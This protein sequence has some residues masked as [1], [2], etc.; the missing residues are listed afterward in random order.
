MATLEKIRSK[1]VL[2]VSIIFVALFLFIITIIDNPFGLFQDTTSA[3][4]VDGEKISIEEVSKRAQSMQSQAQ[5]QRQMQNE[6]RRMQGLPELPAQDDQDYEFLALND[7]IDETLLKKECERMGIVVTDKEVSDIIVG[8]NANP[9]IV[10]EFRQAFNATPEFILSAINNPAENGL[11]QEDAEQLTQAYKEFETSIEFRLLTWKFGTLMN[12]GINANKLDAQAIHNEARTTYSIA[13]V[14]QLIG[15]GEP[16]TDREVEQFYTDHREEFKLPAPTRHVRYVALNIEPSKL[17]CTKALEKVKGDLEKVRESEAGFDDI[18]LNGAY[19]VDHKVSNLAQV[20]RLNV[21]GLQTFVTGAAPDSVAIL[22][23]RT[24]IASSNPHVTLAK[25]VSRENKVNS[26][27]VN[28]VYLDG[29]LSADSVLTSLNEGVN[30]EGLKGVAFVRPDELQFDQVV[31]WLLD[32]LQTLGAGKYMLVGSGDGQQQIAVAI[33]SYGEPEDVFEFYT[34]RYDIAPSRET[35]EELNTRMQEFLISAPNASSFTQENASA[36]N[37]NVQNSMVS[38]ATP[39]L[40]DDMADFRDLVPWAMNAEI[41]SVSK[42]R[43]NSRGDRMAAVAVVEEYK[44]YVPVT[45]PDM[46]DNL[47]MGAQFEKDANTIINKVAGKGKT[48]SDYATLMN[49]QR[50]D[51]ISS[52]NLSDRRF[53]ELGS[54]R[55]HKAGDLVGPMRWNGNVIVASVIETSDSELPINESEASN[56]FINEAYR[57]IFR[58][59]RRNVLLGNEKVDY[60][61]LRFRGTGEE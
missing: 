23:E 4:K 21:P 27:K 26:A 46:Q 30:P 2:L 36:Q 3:A 56:A 6:Q 12:G 53:A 61:L 28:Q 52:V 16:V 15:G 32:S 1:S 20:T 38:E 51:T 8:E 13:S 49:A 59:S 55:G 60:K 44:D 43:N 35:M 57:L 31:P 5:M 34:A 40:G 33:E 39:S 48:L 18:I 47:R 11:T 54:L 41:G 42:A 22:S 7:I 24:A 58:N 19:Q 9:S 17:D 10:A 37:L 29:S 25:L 14:S 50:I 45:F